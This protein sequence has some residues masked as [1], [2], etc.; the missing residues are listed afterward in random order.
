MTKKTRGKGNGKEN[1]NNEVTEEGK[2]S[3]PEKF[4]IPIVN[5]EGV[6]RKCLTEVDL[7]KLELLH[8]Q[9]AENFQRKRAVALD[10]DKTEQDAIRKVRSMRMEATALEQKHAELVDQ[11]LRLT[12]YLSERYETDFRDPEFTYNTETR[13]LNIPVKP[14]KREQQKGVSPP[15]GDTDKN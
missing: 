10:A 6:D 2:T 8:S 3:G 11:R 4:E 15:P 13:V 7:L 5:I 1:G 12:G 14:F 9:I